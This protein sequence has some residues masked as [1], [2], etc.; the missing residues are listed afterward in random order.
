MESKSISLSVKK[1]GTNKMLPTL[2]PG[3][4]SSSQHIAVFHT[5]NPAILTYKLAMII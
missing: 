5:K 3:R 1:T 2:I 4:M